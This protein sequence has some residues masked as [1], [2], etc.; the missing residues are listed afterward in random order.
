MEVPSFV[1]AWQSP[2]LFIQCCCL[3]EGLASCCKVPPALQ[4]VGYWCGKWRNESSL[5]NCHAYFPTI[6]GVKSTKA[7]RSS[8]E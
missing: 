4:V 1:H 8:G 7:L 2:F 6:Y 3:R 5:T